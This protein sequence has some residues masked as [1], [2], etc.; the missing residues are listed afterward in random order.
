MGRKWHNVQSLAPLLL[1]GLLGFACFRTSSNASQKV[2]TP[3]P[4]AVAAAS[5]GAEMRSSDYKKPSQAELIARLTP[6]QYRCTQQEGTEQ[7]F[8]NAYWD[9]KADGIYVDVVSGEPLFASVDKF[10][11]GTGWPS[12]TKYLDDH[13][14][15]RSDHSLLVPRTEVRSKSGDS[16]L[17]HVFADGPAPT[18]M[19]Y[20]I[21]SAALRFVP[22][23]QLVSAGLGH[24]LFV[25]AAHKGWQ[26]ATMAGGCFWGMEELIRKLPGVIT[27]QVGYMGDESVIGSYPVVSS[28]KTNHAESVQVLFEPKQLAYS[29]LLAYFFRIHDPT[30]PNQQGN[31]IGKQYR[32]VIFYHNKEQAE[33]AKAMLASLASAKLWSKPVSTQLVPAGRFYRAE[34]EHQHYLARNPSGYTCHYERPLTIPTSK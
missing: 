26:I 22:L 34:D 3:L 18:G 7:P 32:S 17:G 25:F 4:I 10:D 14:V 1:A 30:T 11:S 27:T 19:R 6:E 9:H 2:T 5:Q 16:H 12:F 13:V 29:N 28:G 31:D 15:E 8:A 21:N 24:Y 33:Q 20:C 23:D